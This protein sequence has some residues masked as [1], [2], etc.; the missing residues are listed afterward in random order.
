MSKKKPTEDLLHALWGGDAQAIEKVFKSGVDLNVRDHQGR[1]LLMEATLEKRADLVKQLLVHGADATL[2]DHE[3]T[4]ALHLA[5]HSHQPEIAQLLV[6]AHAVVDARDHLGHT[7]LFEALSTY[8]GDRDGDAIYVLLL[9]GA[10]KRIKDL[11]GVS[12]EDLSN[13]PSNYDLGQ[14]FR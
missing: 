12:P 11:H 13:E 3:G 4:T 1:T 10:D 8:K 6:D 7:P 9:A 5:A 14:F 2:A